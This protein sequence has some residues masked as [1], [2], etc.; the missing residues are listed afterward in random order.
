MIPATNVPCP[1]VSWSGEPPTKLLEP[2]SFFASSG[3][4]ASTPESITATG[5]SKS[6]GSVVQ[7][8]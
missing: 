4:F 5:T 8:S 7:L 3:W 2:E 6:G 1:E